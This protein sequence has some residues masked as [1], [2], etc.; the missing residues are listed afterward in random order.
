MTSNIEIVKFLEMRH[1][2][3]I[4]FNYLSAI[5]NSFLV[6]YMK[7]VPYDS[8]LLNNIADWRN[9]FPKKVF[10]EWSRNI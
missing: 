9:Y 8:V 6:F 2:L 1:L 4:F 3:G 10:I 5:N 7:S